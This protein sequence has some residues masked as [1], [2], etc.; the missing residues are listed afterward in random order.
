MANPSAVTR[1]HS[2]K[3]A[4]GYLVTKSLG[5]H[6]DVIVGIT[7]RKRLYRLK[8]KKKTDVRGLLSQMG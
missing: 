5:N 1:S 8:K 4:H 7:E 6:I 2:R 3:F